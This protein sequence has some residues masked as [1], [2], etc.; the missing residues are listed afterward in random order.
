MEAALGADGHGFLEQHDALIGLVP[1]ELQGGEAA[2]R[3]HVEMLLATRGY[4]KAFCCGHVGVLPCGGLRVNVGPMKIKD[5][6]PGRRARLSRYD[7]KASTK[8]RW[9]PQRDSNPRLGLER[10][11]PWGVISSTSTPGATAPCP[12]RPR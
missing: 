6:S 9:W 12:S 10:A 8:I 11:S 5:T 3:R 1:E 2:G 7:L 4:D